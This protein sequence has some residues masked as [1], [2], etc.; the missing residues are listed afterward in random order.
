VE[1]KNMTELLAKNI[2]TLDVVTIL[3]DASIG[4]LSKILLKNKVSGVPV[5]DEEG[6][7]VGIV[8]EADIIKENIKVQFPFYFDPLM[9]SAYVVDFEK[10]NEDIK[11][12]LNTKVEAVM[13]HRVKTA[14]PSTPVTEVADMMVSNKINRIP[15][16]DDDKKILGIITRAD[17]IKSMIETKSI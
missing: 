11:D 13:N 17:I 6:K 15:I 10:Y 7:L 2:M 3:P 16:V 8:T 1:V 12:Y 14:D 5:V 4:E 9:V